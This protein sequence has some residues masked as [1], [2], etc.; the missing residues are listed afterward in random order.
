MEKYDWEEVDRYKDGE[1]TIIYVEGWKNGDLYE[2]K[3]DCWEWQYN[4][5]VKPFTIRKVCIK[6]REKATP[7]FN[8][9]AK[10]LNQDFIF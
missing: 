10:C 7:R 3:A 8:M 4:K 6:C 2:A 1:C 9:C 5:S